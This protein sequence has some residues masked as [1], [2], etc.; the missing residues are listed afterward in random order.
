MVTRRDVGKIGL[1]ATLTATVARPVW[2]ASAAETAV[3][4]ARQY[5][6]STINIVW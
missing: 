6:G 2:A 1:A 4:A 5:K 3:K